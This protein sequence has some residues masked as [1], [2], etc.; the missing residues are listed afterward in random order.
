MHQEMDV[1][2]NCEHPLQGKYCSNC[3]Q[4]SDT[5]RFHLKHLMHEGFHA[6]TH[7][8]TGILYLIK[9]LAIRPGVVARQYLEGK[10]KRY[11][12]PFTF[13]LVVLAL[14]AVL[15]KGTNI[16]GAFNKQAFE[17]VS[18][19]DKE[20]ADALKRTEEL[21]TLSEKQTKLTLENTK[22][23][24]FIGL[25]L[26]ALFTWL[27]FK[28][29]GFNYAENLLFNI[30]ITGEQYV[31]FIVL[32]IPIFLLAPSAIVWIMYLYILLVFVY[33]FIAYKQFYQQ[34]W[35]P[36]VWRGVVLQTIWL[37]AFHYMSILFV[38]AFSR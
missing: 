5:H 12:N 38:Q 31:F 11:Y 18:K 24:N 34:R 37:T 16:Y 9:E 17:M 27:F 15:A 33:T 4:K 30:M 10:R 8:D 13:L 6:V 19:L 3:G 29:S 22:I 2:K 23:V 36:V 7:T 26:L 14:H 32:A 20:D 28:K 21:R 25:P 1:C 35:W